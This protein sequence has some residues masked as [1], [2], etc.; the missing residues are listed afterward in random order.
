MN[1][2]MQKN[3]SSSD[4]TSPSARNGYKNLTEAEFLTHE[5]GLARSA[6]TATMTELKG[7]LKNAADLTLWTHHHPW[8]TV[9]VAAAA[10]FTVASAIKGGGGNPLDGLSGVQAGAA[11]ANGSGDAAT[12]S[13]QSKSLMGSLFNLARTAL[14]ASLVSAIRAEGIARAVQ[15]QPSESDSAQAFGQ[16]ES[17]QL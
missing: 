4:T 10:G 5:A 9:G 3:D 14:E 11:A 7:S 16:S 17:A 1:A 15:P 2:V 8:M 6:I 12:G 13:G